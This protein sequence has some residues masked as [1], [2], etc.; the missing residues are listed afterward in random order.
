L[1]TPVGGAAFIAGWLM[2]AYTGRSLQVAPRSDA[3]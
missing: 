3:R 1:A 2:L